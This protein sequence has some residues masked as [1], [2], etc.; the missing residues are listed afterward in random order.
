M[1][2]IAVI[3]LVGIVS[4]QMGRRGV[5]NRKKPPLSECPKPQ[6]I[7]E[8]FPGLKRHER[9]YPVFAQNVSFYRNLIENPYDY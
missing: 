6:N 3:L 5:L 4:Y 1:R 7:N 9:S 8:V 2:D